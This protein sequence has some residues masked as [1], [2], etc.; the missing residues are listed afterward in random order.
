MSKMRNK[1]GYGT[2]VKLSGK[3]RKP[4]EVRVNTRM[5]ERN[6][7]VYDVVGRYSD[8]MEAQNA[9]A[10]YNIDPYD[11]EHSKITFSELFELWFKDKYINTSKKYSKSSID[12][13]N[14]AFKHCS[15]LYNI[16]IEK[17]RV[18]HLQAVLDLDL[19]HATLE[20][21]KILFNQMFDYAAKYDY[22]KKNYAPYARINKEDD[23]IH[24]QPFSTGDIEKL[25]SAYNA[26]SEVCTLPLIL[27]YSGWRIQEFAT[28][29]IDPEK[30]IMQG[31]LKTVASKNRI[32]PIHSKIKDLIILKGS[33]L[34]HDRTENYNNMLLKACKEAGIKEKHTCH[35]CRHT[36]VSLLSSAGVPEIVIKRLVGHAN[37]DITGLYTHK[38]ISELKKEIEKI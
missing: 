7:P 10:A 4:F 9:L 35:D 20:H 31:G 5:D 25:W 19:S 30:D 12:C 29:K 6:Y 26:G 18:N 28:C 21:I 38:D 3:R 16:P 2:V 1:N 17:I 22:I 27:I 8:R 14:A 11:I 34:Q 36:F 23:D 33:E 24:G 32:V 15:T 13:M 37:K